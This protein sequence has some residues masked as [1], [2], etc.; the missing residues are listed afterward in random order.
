MSEAVVVL[1]GLAALAVA[2]L[3]LYEARRRT[4]GDA[5]PIRRLE[6]RLQDLATQL[7]GRIEDSTQAA[8]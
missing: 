7:G 4:T 8:R 1:A 6:A 2:A 3:A 5:E